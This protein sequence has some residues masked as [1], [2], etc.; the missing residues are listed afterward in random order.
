VP[1][2]I[3]IYL[4]ACAIALTAGAWITY[5]H[6]RKGAA[7]LL[8]SFAVYPWLYAMNPLAFITSEA[9]YVFMLSPV[10]AFTIAFCV[11]RMA[12]I[13]VLMVAAVA[14]SIG[15]LSTMHDG[16]SPI[17]SDRPVPIDIGPLVKA[18]DADGVDTAF[19]SYWIAYRLNFETNERITAVGAPY[20]RYP[21]YDDKVRA[22]PK[23]SA[24]IF[25]AGS[26]ADLFFKEFIDRK[27]EPYTLKTV[28]GFAYYL[29]EQKWLPGQVPSSELD[30][31]G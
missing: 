7:L 18:M 16:E 31:L 11:R 12:A 1:G 20:N 26:K 25:V 23:P 17:P 15:G 19:A 13:C 22:D 24:W 29:P 2:G 9:R 8:V 28:G 6:Q 27:G 4:L 30:R 10:I 21:P 14:L 3:G 5:R